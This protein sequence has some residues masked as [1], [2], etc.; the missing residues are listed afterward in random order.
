[1]EAEE[2]LVSCDLRNGAIKV[3][4]HKEK[5]TTNKQIQ[6]DPPMDF[7]PARI[8]SDAKLARAS[9]DPHYHS[10]DARTIHYQGGCTYKLSGSSQ[11]IPVACLQLGFIG[12]YFFNEGEVE[13]HIFLE[14]NKI[15]KILY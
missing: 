5:L 8:P 7:E 6:N 14:K 13:K 2:R 10:F 11:I 15:S 4:F 3:R 9:G 1:M 12:R